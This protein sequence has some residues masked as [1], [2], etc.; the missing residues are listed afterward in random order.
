MSE[1]ILK[2]KETDISDLKPEYD[3][4]KTLSENAKEA[5][6][7]NATLNAVK[8]VKFIEEVKSEIKGSILESTKADRKID[9]IEK[10][11]EIIHKEIDKNSNYYL[12]HEPILHF[13]GIDNSCDM[14]VMKITFA[15][16]VLPYFLTAIL[17]KTP[18]RIITT[19]FDEFNKLL[20]SIADFGKP[21]K[22]FCEFA[23]WTSMASLVVLLV[24]K[25]IE[26]VLN[27]K[28][29]NF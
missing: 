22:L 6:K 17:I 4:L 25:V 28:I 13:G 5:V 21:A 27:I 18:L 8:D 26:S 3:N 23:V 15:I 24:I 1:I 20:I 16:M 11:A 19:I 9:K 2:G 10:S 29:I 7:F 14:A 12:K